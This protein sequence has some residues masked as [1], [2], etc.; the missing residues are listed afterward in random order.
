MSVFSPVIFIELLLMRSST[1]SVDSNGVS[2]RR[3]LRIATRKH[4]SP[5]LHNLQVQSRGKPIARI[6][7]RQVVEKGFL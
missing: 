3:Q 4:L 6:I 7:R 1:L 5:S 2:S